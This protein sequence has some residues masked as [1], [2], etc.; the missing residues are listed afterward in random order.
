MGLHPFHDIQSPVAAGPSDLGI[1]NA[2]PHHSLLSEPMDGHTR[3]TGCLFFRDPVRLVRVFRVDVLICHSGA[4]RY[5]LVL[6]E[7]RP[8]DAICNPP[9]DELLIR[10][11]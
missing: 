10:P 9:L 3:K 7:V 8:V 11:C 1:W 4:P 2:V 5:A 6:T